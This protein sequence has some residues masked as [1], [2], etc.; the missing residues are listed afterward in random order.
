MSDQFYCARCG[1]LFNCSPKARPTWCDDCRKQEQKEYQAE[2][3]KRRKS[4]L[5]RLR[6]ENETLQA[7]AALGR[8]VRRM[9]D[10]SQLL[11]VNDEWVLQKV[12]EPC[13]SSGWSNTPEAALK[14]AGLM[15]VEK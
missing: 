5:A 2:Y 10:V 12:E 13:S 15:E 1:G 9:P 4:E 8:S 7:D 11:R 14:A 3:Y 6:A